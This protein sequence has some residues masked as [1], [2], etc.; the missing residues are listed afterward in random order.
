[1]LVC[2]NNTNAFRNELKKIGKKTTLKNERKNKTNSNINGPCCRVQEQSP[3]FE[4]K[5]KISQVSKSCLIGGVRIDLNNNTIMRD[6]GT[7]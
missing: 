7:I 6:V 3:I 2:K 4:N 1:L 5:H